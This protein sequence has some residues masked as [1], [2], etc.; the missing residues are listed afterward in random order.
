[1]KRLQDCVVYKY[2]PV[3]NTSV[4]PAIFKGHKGKTSTVFSSDEILPKVFFKLDSISVFFDCHNILFKC[5]QSKIIIKKKK[6]EALGL[7]S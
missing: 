4:I 6:A 2:S 7:P 1:M 5:C 3:A